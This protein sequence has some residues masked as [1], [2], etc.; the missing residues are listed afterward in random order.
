MKKVVFKNYKG[1]IIDV[2]PVTQQVYFDFK[3]YIVNFAKM[4]RSDS[5]FPCW[6]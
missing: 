6:G 5:S 1:E 2:D 4:K 3:D